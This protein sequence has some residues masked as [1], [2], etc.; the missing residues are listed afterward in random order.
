VQIPLKAL[1]GAA[2]VALLSP[3]VAT[4]PAAG[5][6]RPAQV[7]LVQ[8]VAATTTSLTLVWPQVVGATG[9]EVDMAGDV[10]MTDRR[11][12]A[13]AGVSTA[14]VSGLQP[15]AS[16][17]F[18]VRAMAG[19]TAGLRSARTCKPTIRSQP[20]APVATYEVVTYNLCTIACPDWGSRRGSAAKRIRQIGADVVALQENAADSRIAERLGETYKLAAQKSGKSLLFRRDRF[21]LVRSGSIDLGRRPGAAVN[22]WAVWAELADRTN[23]GKRVIFT[24]AHLVSGADTVTNDGYRRRNTERL[25]A[26]IARL[27]AAGV[28]VVYAGDFNSHKH[29]RY[30]SPAEVMGA[31]GYYDAYDLAESL[32]R[33][34][35]NSANQMRLVPSIGT[36]YGDHVDHVW[37]DPTTTRVLRWANRA[38][39]AGNLY[40]GPLPSNHNPI[41]VRVKV[42]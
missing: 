3:L 14:T 9:Y 25:V 36:M 38:K 19:R 40:A 4:H 7:G 11:R 27:N 35:F 39:M 21:K 30:D 37:V 2:L 34:N 13:E 26:G 12:V 31:S 29:R 5:A 20:L 15:G 6:D 8:A 16:Y 17:C 22:H 42:G 33:P 41:A 10:T 1:V 23:A 18:Q 28:P 32:I 24:S